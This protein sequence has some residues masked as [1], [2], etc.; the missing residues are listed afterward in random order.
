MRYM[1]V[2]FVKK[3]HPHYLDRL[4][5]PDANEPKGLTSAK[6]HIS[7]TTVLRYEIVVL[8]SSSLALLK[9]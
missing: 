9:D 4:Y 6:G 3:Y 7:L 8:F 1:C 5:N 2:A